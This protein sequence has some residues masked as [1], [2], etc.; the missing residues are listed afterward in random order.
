MTVAVFVIQQPT[1]T[2]TR[3]IKKMHK[4]SESTLDIIN[5]SHSIILLI[6]NHDSQ[7][8]G[9]CGTACRWL[10]ASSNRAKNEL[11]PSSFMMS[12]DNY[13]THTA[14][15]IYCSLQAHKYHSFNRPFCS[16]TCK[17]V[18]ASVA[19]YLK[20]CSFLMRLVPT[21]HWITFMDGDVF[22]PSSGL[23]GARRGQFGKR[24]AA[25]RCSPVPAHP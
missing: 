1:E 20:L 10:L 21:R 15:T 14:Y 8:S 3:N 12:F 24:G 25:R 11:F 23:G 17:L 7:R 9:L 18:K 19:I 13:L 6:I 4:K 16:N 2:N 22:L 5:G